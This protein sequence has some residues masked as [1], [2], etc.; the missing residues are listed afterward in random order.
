VSDVPPVP[1]NGALI[2]A[3]RRAF[4]P[5]GCLALTLDGFELRPGQQAMA[6]AV[7]SVFDRGGHLLAEAGT[8]TGKTLAYLIP[9]ILARERVVVSTGTKNLQ[10]QILEKDLP[11]LRQALGTTF[12]ATCMKGRGN[13]LCLHRFEAFRAAPTLETS[14]DRV[15]LALLEHWAPTTT[16]GDRA[17]VDELP[18]Q[19][20]FWNDVA[21]TTD[22]CLGA[23]CPRFADCFVTRMRQ[24]AAASDVVI[25]NHHLLCAD[26]ALRHHDFGEVIP[27]TP[28][29]VVDEAHQL[30]DVVTQYFG[31]AVGNHR[32]E[33]LVREG[34]RIARDSPSP[35]LI[36][37]AAAHVD[38]CARGFFADLQWGRSAATTRA[39]REGLFDERVRLTPDLLDL[40]GESGLE[41]TG[42]LDALARAAA[43][44]PEAS[45][46]L[47]SVGRRAGELGNDLRM[48]L[49]AEDPAFVYFLEVRGR[50]VFLRATPIDVA[51]IV[52]S[53]LVD[54][55]RS[56]V[57]TSATL[58]VDAS[59]AYAKA[60]LGV[61]EAET[62]CLASEF[63]YRSQALLYLPPRMP[64]PRSP[65]FGEHAAREVVEILQRTEGRAF[66]L[67]TSY[68]TLRDVQ[69][70]IASRLPY[71]LM[72]QGTAPRSLL[73]EAFRGTPNA[74]L[75]ATSSFW[76]GVD[77]AGEALS[78]VVVDKLPFASPAD[79][80]VQA[81]IEAI[82]AR[83]GDAFSDYQVPFAILTLLQGLGRLLRTRSDRG[84]LAVLDP[85]LRTKGYGRRFLEALPPAPI[86]HRL[87]DIERFFAG[88]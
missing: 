75:L 67:F 43:S 55:F 76:Q 54:R 48:L 40:A 19:V 65:S 17:E 36:E 66:V 80:I 60:R 5:D 85:R 57:F 14:A 1:G 6:E 84:V 42:A 21:A 87:D 7:A 3:V 59:F 22:N 82:A 46:D 18:E 31:V 9:A 15:A 86:T 45:E 26:A 20:S 58:A 61:D 77:V 29:L 38:A 32:V 2:E 79:P 24:R 23:E 12:T 27:E 11:V 56:V 53:A 10:E 64:D 34:R 30:E 74:V 62:I 51:A 83:G 8:G 39:P 16:V 35:D 73:V 49:R 78:C 47:R 52:R 63:D 44:L 68:A 72:V 50:T 71:P 33:A 28:W 37:R 70:R 25:V 4:A 41:L 13:Y 88:P 69:A 81:R